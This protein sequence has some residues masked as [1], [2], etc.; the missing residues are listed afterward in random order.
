MKPLFVLD[1][2]L[3]VWGYEVLVINGSQQ[4]DYF[5]RCHLTESSSNLSLSLVLVMK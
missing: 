3:N 1:P 5:F 4:G 2:N